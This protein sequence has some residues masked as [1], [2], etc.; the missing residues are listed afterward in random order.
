MSIRTKRLISSTGVVAAFAAGTLGMTTSTASAASAASTVSATSA[1]RCG[2]S[3]SGPVFG[4]YHYT[5]RNCHSY[6][7]KRK[8]DLR[9]LV[10]GYP[11][12]PCHY[13]RAH[14]SISDSIS[15]PDSV[16]IAGIKS[17]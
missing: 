16:Y 11:D 5:I 14:S 13:I 4:Q 6:P 17:C 2:L 1:A 7:V 3:Y 12:G 15:I 10:V 9:R 8:L